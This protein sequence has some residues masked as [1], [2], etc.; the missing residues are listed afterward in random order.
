M[1]CVICDK[2]IVGYGN[3][4]EPVAGGLCCDRCNTEVVIPTRM[5][6]AKRRLVNNYECGVYQD[7]EVYIQ[8]EP[9]QMQANK[10]KVYLTVREL[11]Y[12]LALAE[13]LETPI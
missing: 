4:A 5:S 12:L 9:L 8:T 11:R 10:G 7:G 6:M 13:S 2:A 1:R 3:N